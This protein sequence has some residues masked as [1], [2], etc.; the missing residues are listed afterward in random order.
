MAEGTGAQSNGR[1]G[2][3]RWEFRVSSTPGVAAFNPPGCMREERALQGLRLRIGTLLWP[4]FSFS[5]SF[6]SFSAVVKAEICIGKWGS[7]TRRIAIPGKRVISRSYL[8][9]VVVER[10]MY[11]EGRLADASDNLVGK[12]YRNGSIDCGCRTVK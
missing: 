1:W 3:F 12:I 9:L 11:L 8:D 7:E 2:G 4:M 6:L 5:F 10:D